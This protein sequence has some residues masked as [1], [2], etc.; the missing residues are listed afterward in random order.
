VAGAS[1]ISAEQ[2]AYWA[3][4]ASLLTSAVNAGEPGTAGFA[5]A[6]QELTQLGALPDAGL[7]PAQRTQEINLVAALNTFFS[8]PGLY[9]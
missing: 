6:A 2:G 1:A 4:A 5:H 3:Q 7:T 8:T 9:S